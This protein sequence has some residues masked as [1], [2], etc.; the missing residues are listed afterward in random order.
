MRYHALPLLVS[1]LGCATASAASPSAASPSAAAPPDYSVVIR[2]GTVYDG[3]GGAPF[4]G[5]VAIHGDR[6]ALCRAARARGAAPRKSTRAARRSHR[7]SSTCWRTRRN[8][9]WSTGGRSAICS[10]GVTLEVMGEDSMGPLSPEMKRRGRQRQGDIKYDDRPGRRSANISTGCEKHGMAPNVAS[11]RRA[12]ARCAPIVLGERD[13]QPTAA[14]LDRDA[15]RWCGQAMEQGAL[16]A[17]HRADLRAQRATRRPPS[18]SR[19]RRKSAR[20]GGIYSAHMRSEGDRLLEEA[21]QETVDIAR[22]SRRAG[23]N[24]SPESRPAAQLGQAR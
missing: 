13:V 15:R 19:S 12:P 18:S 10:Q 7:A 16:G 17:D 9:C 20:C 6:I 8:R 23:R 4:M 22:A 1:A 21:V 3:S 5:D 24:L 11:Y 14:Q 2:G